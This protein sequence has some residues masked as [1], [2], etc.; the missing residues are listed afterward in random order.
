MGRFD[1]PSPYDPV[2]WR[3]GLDEIRAAA[4]RQDDQRQEHEQF[5]EEEKRRAYAEQYGKS[6]VVGIGPR[7]TPVV[8]EPEGPQICAGCEE[9]ETRLETLEADFDRLLKKLG[10]DNERD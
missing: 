8:E 5:L 2:E 4:K 6:S 7:F 10:V 3:R 1:P 9:L